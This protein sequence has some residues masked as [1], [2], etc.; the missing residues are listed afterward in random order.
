MEKQVITQKHLLDILKQQK[1]VTFVTLT[2]VTTPRMRK[3]DNPYYKG[4]GE[5]NLRKISR[6]NGAIGWVYENSVNYQRER[7]GKE[8][9]FES[10]PRQWGQRLYPTPL[11]YHP[12]K[13]KYYLEVKVEKRLE[14]KYVTNNGKEVPIEE[15]KPFLY[16]SSGGRQGVDNKIKLRDYSIKNIKKIRMNSVQYEL[17]GE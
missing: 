7:E 8:A 15:L 14:T 16:N 2:S 6:V 11:V 9:D 5:W 1:G 13:D 10:Y 12:K 3:T 4:S 17:S